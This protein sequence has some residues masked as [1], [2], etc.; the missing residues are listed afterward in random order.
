MPAN[1]AD[2]RR[3]PRLR[4]LRNTLALCLHATTS[5][6]P[7]TMVNQSYMLDKRPP[8]ASVKSFIDEDVIPAL[9]DLAAGVETAGEFLA[10]AARRYP[11]TMLAVAFG[12]GIFTT[13]RRPRRVVYYPTGMR[14][15]TPRQLVQAP[16]KRGFLGALGL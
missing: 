14:K 2:A 13:R 3:F 7:S 11:L 15:P 6:G 10:V 1:A 16:R 8:P 12:A 4:N 5:E 9:I